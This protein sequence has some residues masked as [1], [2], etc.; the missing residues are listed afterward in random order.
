[1]PCVVTNINSPPPAMGLPGT[2]TPKKLARFLK[3]SKFMP[4]IYIGI[5]S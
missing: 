5:F 1:M 4:L 3:T 2:A